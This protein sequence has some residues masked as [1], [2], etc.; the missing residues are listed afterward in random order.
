MPQHALPSTPQIAGVGVGAVLGAV[1][2]SRLVS[3]LTGKLAAGLQRVAVTLL[4][5]AAF[6]AAAGYVLE[7]Y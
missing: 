1:V 5:S 3:T 4:F 7:L 2:L 6:L